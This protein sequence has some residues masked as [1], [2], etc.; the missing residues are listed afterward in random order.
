MF[1][2][3]SGRKACTIEEA[4]SYIWQFIA[5]NN[6]CTDRHIKA[7]SYDFDLYLP[8]LLEIVEYSRD[9]DREGCLAVLEMQRLYMD[10][11]WDLVNQ[12]YLRPG[13]RVISGDTHDGYGKGYSLTLK[14]SA[15]LA[16]RPQ[17]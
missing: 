8:W 17:S 7:H 5:E 15:F 14:G 9:S 2:V 3:C 1:E 16:Q 13:P 6:E 11:A 10:A 4:Q 12:G